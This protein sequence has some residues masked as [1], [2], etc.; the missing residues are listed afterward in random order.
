[1]YRSLLFVPGDS[2]R[3]LAKSETVAPDVV[4]LD[5]EDAV[6][7]EN[8]PA[9]RALVRDYLA[10]S[11]GKRRAAL[12][13]RI[14][15]LS[16]PDALADLAAVMPGRPDGIVQPKAGSPDEARQLGFYL[17]AFEAEHGIASG[18]TRILPVATEVPE[19]L[20]A[21]GG[22]DKVGPRL[23]A[24]TW[25]AEDLSAAIGAMGN[26][27]DDGGW[28]QPFALARSLCLFAAAAAKVAALDTLHADFR[29]PDG[30]AA[31]CRRA[32]RDG[33]SGKIA[34]HPDQ[35]AVINR[36]FTPSAEEVEHA[37]R[38][39][40]LFEANP[41]AG[42]LGLDGQMLDMPHLV[43]ARKTLALAAPSQSHA[44]D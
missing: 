4:I 19:A 28:S 40:A 34:I 41:G 14:N 22:Y 39:V 25:G 21:L 8:R 29:D 38:V 30:L 17:D 44:G 12:F 5:L 1:M 9:A 26:K 35:V 13:V 27:D 11:A 18:A 2:A 31:A 10:A 3:K 33:F 7:A 37:R 36:A 23:C 6:A 20:F 24:L 32:R 16:T 15:P 42:T 43:Q